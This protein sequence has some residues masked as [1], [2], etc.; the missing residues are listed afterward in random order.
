MTTQ[1]MTATQAITAVMDQDTKIDKAQ[2]TQSKLMDTMLEAF[3]NEEHTGVKLVS[4]WNT[5][6][7]LQG[8]AYKVYDDVSDGMVTIEGNKADGKVQTYKSQM[9]KAYAI[10]GN[11]FDNIF[12]WSDIKELCKVEK[13]GLA[14]DFAEAM[15]DLAKLNKI[16]IKNNDHG[17]L[18]FIKGAIASIENNQAS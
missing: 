18:L 5:V 16:A 12:A 8:W 11:S 6:Y 17:A 1:T 14:L 7:S 13:T 9:R 15:Q 4:I 10:N 3:I 2:A